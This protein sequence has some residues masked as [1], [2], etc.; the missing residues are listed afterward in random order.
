ML[1]GDYVANKLG[2]AL[3][4]ASDYLANNPK[5]A[6]GEQTKD[7]DCGEQIAADSQMAQPIDDGAGIPM[8]EY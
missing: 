1:H 3:D 2:A 8:Q 7:Q 5:D 6:A 4:D